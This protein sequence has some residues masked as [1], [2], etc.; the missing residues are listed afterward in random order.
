MST[1]DVISPLIDWVGF[2]TIG[3]DTVIYGGTS[4]IGADYNLMPTISC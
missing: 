2:F 4:D 1:F 3:T